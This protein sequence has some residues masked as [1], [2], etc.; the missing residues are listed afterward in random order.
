MENTDFKAEKELLE[1]TE[2]ENKKIEAELAVL[3][4]EHQSLLVL[5]NALRARMG[6]ESLPVEKVISSG[7]LPVEKPIHRNTNLDTKKSPYLGLNLHQAIERCLKV[8]RQPLSPKDITDLLL[9]GKF[10]TKSSN[11]L[12]MVNTALQRMKKEEYGAKVE[13]HDR[14]WALTE[15]K[16]KKRNSEEIEDMSKDVL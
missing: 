1:K 11:L 16:G 15:W 2:A 14:K 13:N 4:K 3:E 7:V 6:L 5:M 12:A 9:T 10:Y 8:E